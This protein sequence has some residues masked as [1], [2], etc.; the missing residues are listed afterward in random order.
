MG[1]LVLIHSITQTSISNQ[2]PAS[3]GVKAGS[4]RVGISQRTGKHLAD[5]VIHAVMKFKYILYIYI[6]IYFINNRD[7]TNTSIKIINK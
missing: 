4:A 2:F 6:Y 1:A 7:F 5:D 3:V